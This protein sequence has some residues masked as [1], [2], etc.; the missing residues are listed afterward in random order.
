LALG[1]FTLSRWNVKKGSTLIDRSH[2]YLPCSTG[3]KVNFELR[4]FWHYERD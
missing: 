3:L 1:F 4:I 2:R